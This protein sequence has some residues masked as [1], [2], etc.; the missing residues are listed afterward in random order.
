[1][2][3][4][5]QRKRK[6]C[7]SNIDL[8][9]E[10]D[11]KQ[12][13]ITGTVLGLL[14]IGVFL[15]SHTFVYPV[16]MGLMCVVGTYEMLSCIGQKKNSYL[17]VPALI[18]GV[19]SP[20]FAYFYGYGAMLTVIMCYITVLLA[21]SVFFDEK[22][23]I[24]NVCEVFLTTLYVILCFTALL[25]LRYI[26]DVGKYVF[27]LVFV[28]AWITD[29]FAYFTGFF[30]GRHKLIPKISPKKTVEGAIGG[31]VFCI[32]AFIIYG[33]ILEKSADVDVNFILFAF[34]GLI[35]S[36]MSQIGDLIASAIKRTYG[37]KDY[38]NLFPGHGG[39]LDRFDS[40]MILSPFLLFVVENLKLFN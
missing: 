25:R 17:T 33:V 37:I 12:R 27:I 13:I 28:A 35:M 20:V 26:P 15:L 5:T 36:V 8:T 30:L 24:V 34:V 1:M 23:K 7:Q 40:I 32:L 19:V 10:S 39:I 9:K 14:L 2:L 18:A 22:V 4:A 3:P 6:L 31:I 21:E 29:T 11:M 38:S 16:I